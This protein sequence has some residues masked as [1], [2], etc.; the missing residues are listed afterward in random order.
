MPTKSR[1]KDRMQRDHPT[2]EAKELQAGIRACPPMTTCHDRREPELHD[3]APRR[4][5]TQCAAAV[6]TEGTVKD[7]HPEPWRR[8]KGPR[9]R[10]QEGHDTHRHRRRR[11]RSTEFSPG[12]SP[13][14]HRG[15]LVNKPA[16]TK[17]SLHIAIRRRHCRSTAIIRIPRRPT[18]RHPH[19]HREK[20][21]PL[22]RRP[23]QSQMCSPPS[24]AAALA[25]KCSHP[26]TT[27]S[28]A[29][30]RESTTRR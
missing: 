22:Q 28:C 23:P 18:P 12:A 24:R 30:A 11:R 29:P 6:E 20:P 10:P 19:S 9:R 4:V 26:R 27:I 16:N 15:A 17:S 14:P 25:S 8:K 5:T 3:D 1:V 13:T 7:F 21:P 2:P